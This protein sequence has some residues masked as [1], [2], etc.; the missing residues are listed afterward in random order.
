MSFF[1]TPTAMPP[2]NALLPATAKPTATEARSSRADASMTT[3][4]WAL[5]RVPAPSAM[6]A[7]T[8]FAITSVSSAAPTPVVPAPA[9][10]PVI[11]RMSVSSLAVMDTPWS[12]LEKAPLVLICAPCSTMALVSPT[13]TLTDSAPAIPVV[14]A[15][16][17]ATTAEVMSSAASASTTSCLADDTSASPTV[18]EVELATICAAIEAPTPVLPDA[19]TPP[20]TITPVVSVLAFTDTSPLAFTMAPSS[21]RA[22][23]LPKATTTPSTPATAVPLVEAPA[24]TATLVISCRDSALTFTPAFAP[25]EVT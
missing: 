25:F 17:P 24:L 19:A 4:F 20:A 5:T 15:P 1:T 18:A 16:V 11:A 8:V 10:P 9:P 2:L 22:S 13:I 14:P 3:S 21:I 23:V 12:A 7:V 6:P